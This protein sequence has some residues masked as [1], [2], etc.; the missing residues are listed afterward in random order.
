MNNLASYNWLKEY[1]ATSATPEEFARE[2][3]LRS[4]SVEKIDR[5]G[6]RF[7]RMLV[8]LVNEVKP[9]PNADKLRIVVLDIGAETIELVCGGTNVVP[10]MR[11]L[12]ALS[13][14]RVRWHGQGELVTLEETEIR[15]VKS[16]GMICAPSEVGFPELEHGE[17]EIWDLSPLTNAAPGTSAAEALGLDDVLFDVEITTNRP[18]AMG[19]VGLAREASV[20]VGGAFAWQPPVL[21]SDGSGVAL[22][23]TVDDARC[24][25]Y[26]AAAVQGVK[27]AP[28]PWWLQRKLLLA[29]VR[30]INNIVDVTNYVLLEYGQPLHAFDYEALRGGE[31]RVRAAAKHE[32]LRALDGKE[33]VLDGEM[34]IAD[35]DRPI[36]IAGIMGGEETGTSEKTTTVVFE[37]AAFDHVSIRRTS[38]ALNLSSDAQLLFEKGLSTEALPSALARAVALTQEI[39]G[40]T[41]ASEIVDYRR[42]PYEPLVFPLVPSRV[43]AKIGVDIKAEDMVAMLEKLGFAVA[44]DGENALVTVPYWR[45]YDI[46]DAVDLTEEIARMVGYHTMPSVLPSGTPPSTREDRAL[47]WERW[48]KRFLAAAGYD[49]LFGLSFV[50]GEDVARYGDDPAK[51][52]V[53][54]NPLSSDMTHMRTS[55]MPSVLRAVEVNQGHT[56]SGRVFELSRIYRYQENE[57]PEERYELVFGEFGYEDA[58]AAFMRTKG[59]LEAYLRRAGIPV[60]F[61]RREGDAKWHPSRTV[62]VLSGGH[63]IGVLGEVSASV[64][65]AFGVDRRVCVARIDLEALFPSMHET[66]RYAPVSE[67]PAIVRDVS[68][69]LDERTAFGEVAEAVRGADAVIARVALVDIYRGNGVPEGKK[70]VTISL[71]MQTDRT[72]TSDDAER[73]LVA[74]RQVLETAFGGILRS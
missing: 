63:E 34:V 18:D 29:G 22:K 40:G 49:E 61:A 48:S 57:L 44:P 69:V 6:E 45:D 8:G 27:V 25:R 4:M 24:R 3:S 62:T 60:T 12:V 38:R 66:L 42:A 17:R 47:H 30:P 2:L 55:L 50:S 37:A 64:Q 16:A 21:P 54:Y 56:P 59:T 71:T 1:L 53:V 70:S 31:I 39:A 58:E 52:Y 46:E 72:L 20:A 9:H 35:S 13:G 36:A 15:G 43:V 32:T 51:A 74:A 23:V 5:V 41:V 14:A 67:F 28:S 7:A 10:G 68:V 19:R 33:Y 65:T 73:V 11:V 26:M